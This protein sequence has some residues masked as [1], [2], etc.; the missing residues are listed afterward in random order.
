MFCTWEFKCGHSSSLSPHKIIKDY[1]HSCRSKKEGK[2]YGPQARKT[3]DLC[4]LRIGW[5]VVNG[6]GLSSRPYPSPRAPRRNGNDLFS[7]GSFEANY[8]TVKR[9]AI[10]AT[11]N[12]I[13]HNLCRCQRPPKHDPN[14]ITGRQAAHTKTHYCG[15]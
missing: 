10:F 15:E 9:L 1:A 6:H 13:S 5:V 14:G 2:R 3:T 4:P 8:W 11:S 12:P 7:V